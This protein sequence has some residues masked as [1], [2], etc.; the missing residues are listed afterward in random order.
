VPI[1]IAYSFVIP[2]YAFGKKKKEL[3]Y[4]LSDEYSLFYLKFIEEKRAEGAG[5]WE[6]LAQTPVW[7]S[8]SGYAFESICL[9]HVPVIKKALGIAGIYTEAS[10]Y[11]LK[12]SDFGRG[13]QINLLIDRNDHAINLFEIKFY[14]TIQPSGF[15]TKK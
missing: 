3:R 4:R 15:E 2:Y 8:W 13:V 7:K 14:V 9:K 5:T 12:N 11:Y 6:K 10:T 1:F